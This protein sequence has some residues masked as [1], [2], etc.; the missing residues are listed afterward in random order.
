MKT[1]IK[2][3]SI[4]LLLL[5]TLSAIAQDST[6]YKVKLEKFQTKAR[7]GKIVTLVGTGSIVVGAIGFFIGNVSVTTPTGSGSMTGPRSE[8]L[9][10]VG[11]GLCAAGLIAIIPGSINWSVGKKKVRE[12]QIRLDD[13]RSGI[14]YGPG[15]AGFKLAFKF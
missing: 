4:L 6:L 14:Y 5:C 13:L 1:T 12:Y 2:T 10:Y 9:L 11:G 15:Q 3:L 8:A 7:N